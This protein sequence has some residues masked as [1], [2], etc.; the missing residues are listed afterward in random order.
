MTP[1]LLARKALLRRAKRRDAIRT[2]FVPPNSVSRFLLLGMKHIETA[3]PFRFP[4]GTSTL[5][6][7][8]PAAHFGECVA[9]SYPTKPTL[10]LYILQTKQTSPETSVAFNGCISLP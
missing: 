4:F 2:G 6:C 7:G 5:T 8:R 3:L 9:S 10:T 1:L